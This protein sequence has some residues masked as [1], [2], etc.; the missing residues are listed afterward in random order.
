MTKVISNIQYIKNL[1][2][3]MN[4]PISGIYSQEDE[5]AVKQIQ[6]NAGLP[7]DGVVDYATF[8]AIRDITIAADISNDVRRW[9]GF[10][11]DSPLIYGSYGTDAEIFNLYLLKNLDL[12]DYGGRSPRGRFYNRATVDAVEYLNRTY[13]INESPEIASDKLLFIMRQDLIT[14]N[15][16]QKK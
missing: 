1:Q 13:G 15:T 16:D 3:M 5:I 14:R 9:Y 4:R 11:N 10:Q 2:R 6:S 7:V 12:Y 8:L